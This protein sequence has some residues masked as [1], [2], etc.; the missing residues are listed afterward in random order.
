M[1]A[2]ALTLLF[3][4]ALPPLQP[5]PAPYAD[6]YVLVRKDVWDRVD[7][8]DRKLEVCEPALKTAETDLGKMDAVVVEYKAVVVEYR[9]QKAD[10]AKQAQDLLTLAQRQRDY[11]GQ[12]E[13]SCQMS[14]GDKVASVWENVDGALTFAGGYGLC[15]ASVWALNQPT[16]K[17]Q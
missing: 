17:G 1:R 7:A 4:A 11:I 12:L 9:R 8:A 3:T 10:L 5:A 16:F 6:D 15:L 13:N 14:F 2:L